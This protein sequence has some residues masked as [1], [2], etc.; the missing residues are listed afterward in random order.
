[1]L[2]SEAVNPSSPDA[3]DAPLPAPPRLPR[4]RD[5]PT[6]RT[7]LTV[8]AIV[9]AAIEVLD[10]T[11][12][13]ELSM[14]KVGARLGTG[15]ASLYAHVSGKD[16]LLELV[17]DEL[18]GRV[19][20]PEPDPETWRE[21]VRRAL[22]DLHRVLASHRDVA[23]VGLGRVPITPKALAA[24]DGLAALLLAGGLTPRVAGLGIDQLT[25]FVAA[26]AFEDG[27]LENTGMSPADIDTYYTE[28]HAFYD[29][30][31]SERFP[32]LAAVAPGLTGPDGEER[33]EFG[34]SAILAGMEALSAS[35]RAGA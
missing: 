5:P 18:V 33:L 7:A 20:L 26:S 12:V 30:L 28:V 34:I 9:A 23:L 17:F 25:L 15:A 14:R 13:A 8:D 19:A 32:S 29:Q 27:L 22:H 2:Y 35:E 3:A 16:E 11:G 21:Q 10:E 4:R 31:P 1:M 6:R 24:A